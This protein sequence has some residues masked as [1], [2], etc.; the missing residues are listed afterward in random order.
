[1][2]SLRYFYLRLRRLSASPYSVAIGFACGVFAIA[3][4]FLGCQML[5]GAI[6]A[7]LL[8]GNIVASAIG[9]FA[10]NPLTYPVI[11]LST[12]KIGNAILGT[13]G[14]TGHIDV[15]GRAGMMLD[16][17]LELSPLRIASGFEAFW[18]VLK[19]MALGSIPVG[20]L[21]AAVSYTFMWRML[22]MARRE[23]QGRLRAA[24]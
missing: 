18:P 7:W 23:R 22:H 21:I 2:R 9:S 17:I 5:L 13:A 19:P 1:M 24:A 4:P 11:W 15:Q 10:G 12:Y 3:T 8:R 16:G 20:F 14:E 6:I